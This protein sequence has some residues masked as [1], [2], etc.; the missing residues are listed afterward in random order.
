MLKNNLAA[1][2][3]ITPEEAE[4]RV[5]KAGFNPKIRVQ[6]LSLEDWVKLLGEFG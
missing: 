3:Y 4:K 6:E 2:Y 5:K 1:G